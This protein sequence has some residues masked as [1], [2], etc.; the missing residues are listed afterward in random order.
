MDIIEH[1]VETIKDRMHCPSTGEVI[2]SPGHEAIDG[3]ANAF[4]AYWHGEILDDP[5]I[6]DP[7][8]LDAWKEFFEENWEEAIE[9]MSFYEMVEKFLKEFKSD[10]WIVYKC[11][12][13]GMACGPVNSTIYMVVAA[14][15]VMEQDPE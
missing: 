14:E 8:L 4:I 9:D 12:F 15:T 10:Q 11:K 7:V 2:F 13:P 3:K 6:K 1:D 5:E